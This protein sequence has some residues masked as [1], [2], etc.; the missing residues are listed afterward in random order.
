M[1]EELSMRRLSLALAL[2]VSCRVSPLLA[3]NNLVR[4]PQNAATLDAAIQT[5]SDGG[6]IEMSAGTYPTPASGFSIKNANARK[7]F[8]IRA[9]A[10]AA[11]ALDGSGSRSLVRIVS[12]GSK[13]VVFQGIT[14]Q[15]GFTTDGSFAGGGNFSRAQAQFPKRGVPGKRPHGL[16]PG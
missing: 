6:V 16:A 3:A 12:N 4:V 8:V 7:S 14:F 13:L 5:V 11:V 9:A 2:A 15:N 10:G 1:K